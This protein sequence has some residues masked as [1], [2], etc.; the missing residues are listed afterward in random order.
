MKV[1]GDFLFFAGAL[2][3]RKVARSAHI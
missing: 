1:D 3:N 2:P